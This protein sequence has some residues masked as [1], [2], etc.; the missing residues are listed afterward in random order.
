MEVE[1][2]PASGSSG[3]ILQ[4]LI[5]DT[6]ADASAL[7][8]ADCQQLGLD[9]TR[10]RPVQMSGVAGGVAMSLLFPVW[11]CLDGQEYPCRLQ[12]DFIGTEPSW[13]ATY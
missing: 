10:G 8:W 1:F 4:Q 7:P 2:R 12:A 6:G 3:V 9:P 13:G 11:A 5:A